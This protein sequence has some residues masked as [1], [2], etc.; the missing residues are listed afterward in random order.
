MKRW[1]ATAN[2]EQRM[3]AASLALLALEIPAIVLLR[4]TEVIR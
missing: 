2:L 3:G 4:L 1:W